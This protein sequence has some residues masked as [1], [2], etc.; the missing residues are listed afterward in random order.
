MFVGYSGRESDSFRLW[1]PE[2]NRVIVTRDVTFLG[3]MFYLQPENSEYQV[4]EDAGTPAQVEPGDLEGAT[5]DEVG[6]DAVDEEG[7]DDDDGDDD[8][9]SVKSITWADE[10]EAQDEQVESEAGGNATTVAPVT[11]RSGRTVIPTSRYITEISNSI[12][13]NVHS[14]AAEL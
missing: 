4:I 3:R 7:I 12:V 2:T 10:V 14:S 5:G 11:T 1:N 9:N 13:E 6:D 8:A